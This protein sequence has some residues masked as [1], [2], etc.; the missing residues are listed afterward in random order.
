[1]VARSLPSWA[2]WREVPSLTGGRR[3]EQAPRSHRFW[4][5][6]AHD[7]QRPQDGMNE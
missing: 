4:W 5:P 6:L 2:W 7:G 3:Q 1:M